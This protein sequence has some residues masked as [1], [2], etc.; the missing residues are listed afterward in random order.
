MRSPVLCPMFGPAVIGVLLMSAPAYTEME[1][2]DTLNTAGML[3]YQ[4]RDFGMAK[5]MFHRALDML[6]EH[7]AQD[8]REEPNPLAAT[9]L[10]NL[11]ATHEALGEYAQAELRYRHALTMIEAI[12]G[13]DHPDVAVG[14]HNL[15][16]LF[17]AQRAFARAETLWQR[18]LSISE[19][20]LGTQHPHLVQPLVTLGIVTQAQHKFARAEM[21]YVR[22]IRIV[23]QSLGAEHPNLLP[24]YARYAALLRQD[25]RTEEAEAVEQRIETI[26]SHPQT[27][28]NRWHDEP[29]D[30]PGS[31]PTSLAGGLTGLL[32]GTASAP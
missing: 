4:Q 30:R 20:A 19:R 5:T 25:R 10:N 9:T 8:G 17:F 3:A 32:S 21:Y 18:G 24:L 2:W 28:S 1:S 23:E 13:A 22:A 15:A 26:R 29:A 11:A 27:S 6:A 31:V 7:P 14:L 12:Q 16:S